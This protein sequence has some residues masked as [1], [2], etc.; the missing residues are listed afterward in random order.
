MVLVF[1]IIFHKPEF[2]ADEFSAALIEFA[3]Q[4]NIKII[5]NNASKGD[6]GILL[7]MYSRSTGNTRTSLEK[8]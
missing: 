7:R 2:M 1:L 6:T 4:N 3:N 8:P 5:F